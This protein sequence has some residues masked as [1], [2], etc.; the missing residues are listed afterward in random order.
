MWRLIGVLL[1]IFYVGTVGAEPAPRHFGY[2]L[3]ADALAAN[4]A[5]AIAKLAG[6]DWLILDTAFT[7]GDDWR[8]RDLATLHARGQTVLAY[9]SIGEAENYR[10]YWQAAWLRQ[11]PAWLLKENPDWAGNY[12][13]RYWQ[14]EWQQL[15]LARLDEILHAGFDGMYLDIVDGYEYFEHGQAGRRNP[16]T[17]HSY[18][19]DMIA[20]V[21]Q[22]ADY[23]R[24]RQPNF[25]VVPQNGIALLTDSPYRA[26]IDA[27]GIEDL[28]TEGDQPQPAAQIAE[29]LKLLALLQSK[30][31]LLTEYPSKT[32]LQQRVRQ[33]ASQAGLIWLVTDRGLKTLGQSGT[34]P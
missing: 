12:R 3:Q 21:T 5:A 7:A 1:G 11:R 17:G 31:V 29:N 14:A 34:A 23:A 2:V 22:L 13:V 19:E 10:G 25:R 6:R 18:R 4:R 26:M 28:F 15:I 32:N 8:P 33:R 27:I 30:P 9:F 20:W 24:K 16:E